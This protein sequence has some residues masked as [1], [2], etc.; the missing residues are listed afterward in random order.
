MGEKKCQTNVYTLPEKSIYH[1]D[2]FKNIHLYNLTLIPY[3]P[4]QRILRRCDKPLIKLLNERIPSGGGDPLYYLVLDPIPDFIRKQQIQMTQSRRLQD[5]HIG[6]DNIILD[7]EKLDIGQIPM[8][9]PV[10]PQSDLPHIQNIHNVLVLTLEQYVEIMDMVRKRGL[11]VATRNRL[12]REEKR[13]DQYDDVTNYYKRCQ[14]IVKNA[15]QELNQTQRLQGAAIVAYLKQLL[16]K[17]Q[18]TKRQQTPKTPGRPSPFSGLFR[19]PSLGSS[20]GNR[21]PDSSGRRLSWSGVTVAPV[22]PRTGR[23]SF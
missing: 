2:K 19:I 3:K 22:T 18:N 12:Q 7:A 23:T 9:R 15:I 10:P 6:Y 4:G 16:P 11:F 21:R 20:S 5:V 14:A 13:R 8:F 17:Q 1:T